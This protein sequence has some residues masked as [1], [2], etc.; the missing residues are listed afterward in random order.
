MQQ[1]ESCWNS[2]H[3]VL[4]CYNELSILVIVLDCVSGSCFFVADCMECLQIVGAPLLHQ[5]LRIF[6]FHS[7]D[8]IHSCYCPFLFVFSPSD[9]LASNLKSNPRLFQIYLL[10][11]LHVE[12]KTTSPVPR[13]ICQPSF[14]NKVHHYTMLRSLVSCCCV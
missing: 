4:R 11:E 1:I 3:P 14:Y 13:F 2:F 7:G 9:I 8:L 10:I 6:Y 5:T 12:R